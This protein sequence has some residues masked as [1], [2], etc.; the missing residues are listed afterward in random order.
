MRD[1]NVKDFGAVGDGVADDQPAF[2][3][4]V[5]ALS[6]KAGTVRVPRGVYSFKQPLD[7]KSA[8]LIGDQE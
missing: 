1:L 5:D 4:A 2:Q 8:K 7:I 6:G 3:A